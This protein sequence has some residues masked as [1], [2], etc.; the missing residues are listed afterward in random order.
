M[1]PLQMANAECPNWNKGAC[2]GMRIAD[3]LTPLP[4]KALDK[5]LLATGKR[6][7]YFEEC[8]LPMAAMATEPIKARSLTDA[9]DTY[10]IEHRLSGVVRQCP[11]CG[12]PLPA[13]RRFCQDCV[14][15]QR[16][17]TYRESKR[18]T[19]VDMSTVKPI[20]GHFQA[21]ESRV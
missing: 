16:K 5:C 6:C 2:D 3:D 19:R 21:I 18:K 17:I 14:V 4:G 8:V 1:T 11:G 10:R 13:R 7:D 20:F 15:K 9:A 12:R